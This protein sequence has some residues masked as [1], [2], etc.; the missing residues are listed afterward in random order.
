[1]REESQ[2]QVDAIKA[3]LNMLPYP[4]EFEDF[5]IKKAVELK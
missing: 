3:H 1:M 5:L 4:G 2:E